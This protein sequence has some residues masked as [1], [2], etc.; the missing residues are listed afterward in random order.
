MGFTFARRCPDARQPFRA[1]GR[2]LP[3]KAGWD[4]HLIKFPVAMFEIFE[5]VSPEWSPHLVA[6]AS[7]SFQ[8]SDRPDT[9]L[10]KQFGEAIREL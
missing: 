7:L 5:T 6:A 9:D 10:M 8:G 3:R 4:P 1:A 2:L